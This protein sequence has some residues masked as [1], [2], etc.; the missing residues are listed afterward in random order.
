MLSNKVTMAQTCAQ[1]RLQMCLAL[2]VGWLS[3]HHLLL[4]ALFVIVLTPPHE[5]T[6]CCGRS[7]RGPLAIRTTRFLANIAQDNEDMFLFAMA[8]LGFLATVSL[9]NKSFKSTII[10]CVIPFDVA[11]W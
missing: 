9:T 11:N 6:R 3:P 2:T 8:I 10:V 1:V 4:A 5:H 7:W